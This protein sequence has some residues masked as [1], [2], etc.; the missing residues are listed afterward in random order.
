MSVEWQDEEHMKL[1]VIFRTI[2]IGTELLNTEYP[3]RRLYEKYYMSFE[4]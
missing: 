1:C 4:N 2:T 3:Y